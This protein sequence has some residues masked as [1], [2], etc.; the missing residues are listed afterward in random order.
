M[1]EKSEAMG[2]FQKTMNSSLGVL[3]VAVQAK[4][5]KFLSGDELMKK[6]VVW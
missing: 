2:I 5:L 1:G 4:E 6:K 3:G